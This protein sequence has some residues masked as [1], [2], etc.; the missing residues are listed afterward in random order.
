MYCYAASSARK[1]TWRTTEAYFLFFLLTAAKTAAKVPSSYSELGRSRLSSCSVSL[2]NWLRRRAGARFRN[3]RCSSH[4]DS[5]RLVRFVSFIE[6]SR[7]SVST[8]YVEA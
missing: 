6:S 2:S 7:G 3:V 4:V 8:K 1:T 5:L